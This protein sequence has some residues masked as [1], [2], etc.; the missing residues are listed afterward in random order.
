MISRKNITGGLWDGP[1]S[2]RR[3]CCHV[4]AYAWDSEMAQ[5]SNHSVSLWF[6]FEISV[7]CQNS[8]MAH[9]FKS[10]DSE[11]A[12][13]SKRNGIRGR[14]SPNFG[15]SQNFR[16]KKSG[17]SQNFDTWLIFRAKIKEKLNG[18]NFG[19]SQNRMHMPS[20]DNIS[21][22]DFLGHLGDPPVLTSLFSYGAIEKLK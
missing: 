3:R 11:M 5:N 2:H 1:K 9:F 16:T 10:E 19:P 17:P 20:R 18:S 22:D 7:T 13:N 8:E 4:K 12:Q 6:W 21:F 14:G 15:P